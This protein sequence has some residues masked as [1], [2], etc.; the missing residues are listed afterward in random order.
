M[1]VAYSSCCAACGIA[2]VDDIKLVPC[3]GCDLVRYC[4]DDCQRDN[5][6]EHE[7]EC[8]KRAAELRDDELLFKQPES[9]HMGDCPI[10]CLPLSLDMTKSIIYTCCSKLICKGCDH[11][12]KIR[13]YEMRLT[14]NKC[15]F[16]REPAPETD[17]E[18]NKLRTKRIEAN[19]TDAI[20]MEGLKQHEKGKYRKAFKFYTKAAELGD[21]QAHYGLAGLYKF[22]NG[23][24]K[25]EGKIIHHL[26]K[27]A[28][29]GHPNAR[30]NLGCEE[31]ENGNIERAVKHWIIAA[32]QGD[33]DAIKNLM[34][35]F[36][37]GL[38]KKD[39]LAATLRA[40]KAAV[41]ATKSPQRKAAEEFYL[42]QRQSS[43]TS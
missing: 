25:D 18:E 38:V 42:I 23:V 12:N 13:E 27:A 39:V 24:E 2:E 15:L 36:K 7:E 28:I 9:T 17:V 26:E 8:R 21:A 6:S 30:F 40:Q 20:C 3:D 33:D 5:K 19:D 43:T 29:G 35:A 4:S 34:I 10:C 1:S 41:D 32:T 11:A 37:L 14:E 16:C 31:E 22:G